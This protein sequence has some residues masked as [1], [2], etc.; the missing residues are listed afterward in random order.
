MARRNWSR[1]YVEN[2]VSSYHTNDN[3]SLRFV[4][5]RL[6]NP[7]NQATLSFVDLSH[8][9]PE[10]HWAIPRPGPP[11]CTLSGF[12]PDSWSRFPTIPAACTGV[13]PWPTK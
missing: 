12:I 4:V 5:G 10:P 6:R 8:R 7:A 2:V 11:G 1:P 3:C 9:P 13:N